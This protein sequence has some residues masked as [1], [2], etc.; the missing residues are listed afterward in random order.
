M[1][2]HYNY[3]LYCGCANIRDMLFTMKNMRERVCFF[4][5]NHYGNQGL[6]QNRVHFRRQSSLN[7]GVIK[8]FCASH[9]VQK[10][11]ERPPGIYSRLL[12]FIS[13]LFLREGGIWTDATPGGLLPTRKMNT[14]AR[15]A[16]LD[17]LPRHKIALFSRWSSAFIISI[18]GDNLKS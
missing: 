13:L 2:S 1:G 4:F 16:P 6:P 5:S 8:I 12:Q 14:P 15:T 10:L 11:R 7:E 9:P 17:G 18:L 3:K